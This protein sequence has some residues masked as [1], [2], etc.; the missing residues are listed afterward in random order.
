MKNA[1][2]CFL[3]FLRLLIPTQNVAYIFVLALIPDTDAYK[4]F[5]HWLYWL[6]IFYML[7]LPF[8]FVCAHVAHMC[9]WYKIG[10]INP[11]IVPTLMFITPRS[12]DAA[13]LKL[14]VWITSALV[15]LLIIIWLQNSK[16]PIDDLRCDNGG[17]DCCGGGKC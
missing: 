5:V 7:S 1:H 11:I 9:I 6:Y 10:I 13:I 3:N 16:H 12:W 15:L 8:M 4:L 17:G 2:K 14:G